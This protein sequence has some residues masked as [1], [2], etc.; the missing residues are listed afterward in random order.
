MLPSLGDKKIKDKYS[1]RKILEVLDLATGDTLQKNSITKDVLRRK[2]D[3]EVENLALSWQLQETMRLS[4]ELLLP[5]DTSTSTGRSSQDTIRSSDSFGSPQNLKMPELSDHIVGEIDNLI[6]GLAPSEEV[7]KLRE[8]VVDFVKGLALVTHR[9]LAYTTG[10]DVRDAFTVQGELD[11][12]L[13]LSRRQYVRPFVKL[14][15]ALCTVASN[16]S[17]EET[18]QHEGGHHIGFMIERV[19]Y[20]FLNAVEKCKAN[21]NGVSVDISANQIRKLVESIFL[22]NIDKAVGKNHLFHRSLYLLKAWFSFEA[23]KYTNS[24]DISV[25]GESSS[26]LSSWCL[27]VM[28]ILIFNIFGK[29]IYHPFQALGVFLEYYDALDIESSAITIHGPTPCDTPAEVSAVD[30]KPFFDPDLLASPRQQ[31]AGLV[32]AAFR[33]IKADKEYEEKLA[34]GMLDLDLSDQEH[35]ENEDELVVGEIIVSNDDDSD[36]S[37]EHA[38]PFIPSFRSEARKFKK[39]FINLMDP[40]EPNLN[41]TRHVDTFCATSIKYLIQAGARAYSEFLLNNIEENKPISDFFQFASVYVQH[42]QVGTASFFDSKC[43]EFESSLEIMQLILCSVPSLGGLARL[44]VYI[45]EQRGPLPVGEVGKQ[46][47]EF[48]GSDLLVKNIKQRYGGLKKVIEMHENLF[49]LGLEHPFNPTVSLKDNFE[50]TPFPMKHVEVEGGSNSPVISTNKTSFLPLTKADSNPKD[51]KNKS[52]TNETTASI[53]PS[54]LPPALTIP[55]DDGGKKSKGKDG[56]RSRGNSNLSEDNN[57]KGGG[58][59]S[60]RKAR[61]NRKFKGNYFPYGGTTAGGGSNSRYPQQMQIPYDQMNMHRMYGNQQ[62]HMMPPQVAMYPLYNFSSQ[63]YDASGP[64]NLNGAK[65][66][67]APPNDRATEKK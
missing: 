17:F 63:F 9:S 7:L 49:S 21:M 29:K 23:P 54:P 3:D 25:F 31:L 51:E 8:N 61:N 41:L 10:W 34:S 43:D 40:L 19:S 58:N 64:V 67:D 66:Y 13:C 12:T 60:P 39:G 15:E 18:E 37:A 26:K 53:T 62:F 65:F 6:L 4:K 55:A 57:A 24:A 14:N 5:S 47:L 35:L 38:H 36:E 59:Y 42:K 56:Q 28:M 33:S 1:E 11:I 32:I 46:L 20:S 22:E 30:I 2:S 27:S 45:L 50:P 44:I 16:Q 48:T 52:N